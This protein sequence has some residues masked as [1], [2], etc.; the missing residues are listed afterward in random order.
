MLDL[1]K[2]YGVSFLELLSKILEEKMCNVTKNGKKRFCTI[3]KI[4]FVS[5]KYF[6]SIFYFLF[7]SSVDLHQFKSN[8]QMTKTTRR[9]PD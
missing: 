5:D 2:R 9:I 1:K 7:L 8:E 3:I 4:F 6:S